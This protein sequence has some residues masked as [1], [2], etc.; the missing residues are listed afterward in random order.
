MLLPYKIFLKQLKKK[1]G[2]KPNMTTKD[3]QKIMNETDYDLF[4]HILTYPLGKP[5]KKDVP[6]HLQHLSDEALE[7]LRYIFRAR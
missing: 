7:G 3:V 1:Y 4:A 5:T 2:I 6:I